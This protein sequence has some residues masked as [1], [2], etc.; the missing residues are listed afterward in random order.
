MIAK[1]ANDALRLDQKKPLHTTHHFNQS[2]DPKN[3]QLRLGSTKYDNKF[4][5]NVVS[6]VPIQ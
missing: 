1:I 6:H 5:S 3:N 4:R 2:Y